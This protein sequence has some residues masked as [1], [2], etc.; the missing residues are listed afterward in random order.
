MLLPIHLRPHSL[1]L[2]W[3]LTPQEFQAIYRLHPLMSSN[4]EITLLL[5]LQD[6]PRMVNFRFNPET[7]LERISVD[8]LMSEAFTDDRNDWHAGEKKT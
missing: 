5:S 8:L 3:A 2:N 1:K 7:G 4:S 6:K